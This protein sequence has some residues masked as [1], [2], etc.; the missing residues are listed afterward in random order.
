[1]G[2]VKVFWTQDLGEQAFVQSLLQSYGIPCIEENPF[3]E[4]F[5]LW[6]NPFFR[7]FSLSVPANRAGRARRVLARHR[8][9]QPEDVSPFRQ[10]IALGMLAI[11]A[12]GI[13]IGLAG[14][15]LR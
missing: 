4:R 6:S 14:G 3:A 9:L 1:M 2:C 10:H 12:F 7:T 11:M 5:S 8:A 15:L 13:L